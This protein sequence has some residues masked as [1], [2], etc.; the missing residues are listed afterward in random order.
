MTNLKKLN[1][2][3]QDYDPL[4]FAKE[5]HEV[6]AI[7][8]NGGTMLIPT[9]KIDIFTKGYVN[10]TKEYKIFDWTGRID[11]LRILDRLK[12]SLSS[13]EKN[14]DNYKKHLESLNRQKQES[15]KRLSYKVGS[16]AKDFKK[17]LTSKTYL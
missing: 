8:I 7:K 17:F 13:K 11:V 1:K 16:L 10:R 15:N 3:L 5:S 2:V 14:A 12:R 9:G 6:S 4:L